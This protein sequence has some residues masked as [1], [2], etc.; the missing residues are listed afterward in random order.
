M[1]EQL[2]TLI[3]Q[4]RALEAY[5]LGIAQKPLREWPGPEGK[6]VA[7]RLA[8][9]LGAP[10]LA[11]ALFEVAYRLAPHDNATRVYKSSEIWQ[12]SGALRAWEFLRDLEQGKQDRHT[13]DLHAMKALLLAE[14]RDFDRAQAH[15]S[16]GLEL[17]VDNAWLYVVRG[18][19]HLKADEYERAEEAALMARSLNPRMPLASSLLAHLLAIRSQGRE[20]IELLRADVQECRDHCLAVQLSQQLRHEGRF[21]EALDAL[22][23][24][25]ELAPLAEPQV[26]KMLTAMSAHLHFLD[27]NNEQ[28]LEEARLVATGFHRGLQKIASNPVTAARKLIQVPFVRQHYETCAPATLAALCQWYGRKADHLEI[29]DRICYGGT[30]AHAQRAWA[31]ANGFLVR[32]F[33]L[34]A[35][36]ARALID[37][38]LPIAVATQE[39][40]SG[41]MQ[42]VVGYD[43]RRRVLLVRDPY[44]P[45]ITEWDSEAFFDRYRSTGPRAM[46]LVPIERASAA[47]DLVL[48]DEMLYACLYR[49]ES[50]LEKH[51]HHQA[52]VEARRMSTMAPGH[53][54]SLLARFSLC[55]YEGDHFATLT[56][57]TQLHEKYPDS[58]RFGMIRLSALGNLQRID[59][60]NQLLAEMRRS[61]PHPML[62]LMAVR[63]GNSNADRDGSARKALRRALPML[64]HGHQAMMQ[65]A[66]LLFRNGEREAA[67]D[68]I[69]LAATNNDTDESVS[70]MFY[71]MWST[72]GRREEALEVLRRRHRRYRHLSS[73][74]SLSL[75]KALS[76]SGLAEEAQVVLGEAVAARAEDA[77]LH[78]YLA[79]QAAY[80]DDLTGARAALERIQG[81]RARGEI[82]GLEI[83]ILLLEGAVDSA[84]RLAEEWTFREPLST[85]AWM[86][87]L[88]LANAVKGWQSSQ[89]VMAA[90]VEENLHHIPLLEMAV[91]SPFM[92]SPEQRIPILS[93]MLETNPSSRQLRRALILAECPNFEG[94]AWEEHLRLLAE[95][96][97]GAWDAAMLR[98]I[99][100]VRSS[101]D[102]AVVYA[103]LGTG[104]L[105][106]D[107][108][109]IREVLTHCARGELRRQLLDRLCAQ[110][111]ADGPHATGIEVLVSVL[112]GQDNELE[113]EARLRSLHDRYPE[114]PLVS[115]AIARS[116]VLRSRFSG[117]NRSVVQQMAQARM[118]LRFLDLALANHPTSS[119][120]WLA[121][122]YLLE[123]IEDAQGQR[124]ALQRS[125]QLNPESESVMTALGICL[126]KA[127]QADAGITMLRMCV[128]R[129][130]FSIHTHWNLIYGLTQS[131]QNEKI[132]AAS[133][134]A[135]RLCRNESRAWEILFQ[136]ARPLCSEAEFASIVDEESRG[137]ASN[138][139]LSYS[140]ARACLNAELPSLALAIS[141]RATLASPADADLASL[142]CFCIA[143]IK[144]LQEAYIEIESGLSRVAHPSTLHVLRARFRKQ[145]EDLESART[146]L[147]R[148]IELDPALGQARILLAEVLIAKRLPEDALKQLEPVA[149]DPEH[150]CA[151]ASLRVEALLACSNPA[152]AQPVIAGYAADEEVLAEHRVWL[153]MIS[154]NHRFLPEVQELLRLQLNQPNRHPGLEGVAQV[155]LT[156]KAG[157]I[158][159]SLHHLRTLLTDGSVDS[160]FVYEAL[161]C[162]RDHGC[163]SQA[164]ALLT[165]LQ[166][167]DGLAAE[168]S[169]SATWW[170]C[171][172][173][174]YQFVYDHLSR[175][176]PQSKASALAWE[177]AIS[178]F[179]KSENWAVVNHCAQAAKAAKLLTDRSRHAW[180]EALQASGSDGDAY[181]VLMSGSLEDCDPRLIY[182]VLDYSVESG[183][184]AETEGLLR[185]LVQRTASPALATEHALVLL[186]LNRI[187]EAVQVLPQQVGEEWPPEFKRFHELAGAGLQAV[188]NPDRKAAFAACVLLY[189]KQGKAMS[190]S[191][192]GNMPRKEILYRARWRL[193][194]S[195]LT[196]WFRGQLF[197]LLE[198]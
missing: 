99:A 15:V 138:A 195:H 133:V 149:N 145:E 5:E 101:A 152:A 163:G 187:D 169:Y 130:P 142:Y 139:E 109:E 141:E 27:G 85:T 186:L 197:F 196:S 100:L 198:I 17:N 157:G 4:G 131:G 172:V 122:S 72:A 77:D 134:R 136:S 69:R 7:G 178:C 36:N 181:R 105:D 164:S 59:E 177:G 47:A 87:R 148:A 98:C 38:D 30:A 156:V 119:D 176:S 175:L 95:E 102:A 103:H 50:A 49:L 129:D 165:D 52:G 13:A 126:M 25:R 92:Q 88:R 120:L 108:P 150:K 135:L 34:T 37:R 70:L 93:R 146:D 194:V 74:P 154:V 66:S 28:A 16:L 90:M 118:G 110:M 51:D 86:T 73:G 159:D 40:A 180:V 170:L 12:R 31:E 162:M 111:L 58:L 53:E 45:E 97:G 55:A 82:Y 192:F 167:G 68:V 64:G 29:A 35:E 89:E 56:I 151:V 160:Q 115:D 106:L 166:R 173:A 67:L 22:S 143:R 20:A 54:L 158:S 26:Q 75:A 19:V 41:H 114:H 184:L 124:E 79:T 61:T 123:V 132:V 1:F 21:K 185:V 57:S 190:G 96:N 91:R 43:D 161:R 112:E 10:R 168:H 60:R 113:L 127:Q 116:F 14:F 18:R 155:L 83:Q 76:A 78:H 46:L 188:R 11:S 137:V 71:G 9:R 80:S 94:A 174:S 121:K 140:L 48:D 171:T 153:L 104:A 193:Q 23:T 6:I 182:K 63:E 117:S 191:E 42:A 183:A 39:V 2:A 84:L 81:S 8:N 3:E 65:Y 125:L 107:D 189:R 144:S 179:Q 32:E 33:R 128:A 24:A 62:E 44:N 147:E